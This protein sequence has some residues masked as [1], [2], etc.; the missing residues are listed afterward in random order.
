[1]SQKKISLI[2]HGCGNTKNL[3]RAFDHLQLES[4]I[5]TAA[6]ADIPTD[7]I[8]VLPGVGAFDAAKKNLQKSG[9]WELLKFRA[10]E[11]QKIFGIC[12]G[13]Q[14]LFENSAEGTSPGL[15]LLPGQVLKLPHL[16]MGWS[17]IL[18]ESREKKEWLYFAHRYFVPWVDSTAHST[19]NSKF[20]F[21][22]SVGLGS[23]SVEN[24]S[25]CQFH[26]ERSGP[27]GLALLKQFL[28]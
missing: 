21:E 3:K 1:M 23:C 12:L 27:A 17:Q 11:K 14:L 28:A 4:E 19:A 10:G 24:I 9:L 25:G 18:F 16:H 2:D 13:F 22:S 5:F 7:S 8:L 6:S 15:G 20:T 26:P